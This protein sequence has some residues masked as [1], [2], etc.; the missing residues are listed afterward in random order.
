[1]KIVVID[2]DDLASAYGHAVAAGNSMSMQ[3]KAA[4]TEWLQ[5]CVNGYLRTMA[6]TQDEKT[7]RRAQGAVGAYED[8][9]DLLSERS[10]EV[11]RA[12]ARKEV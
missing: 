10:V 2:S 9:I 3:Q 1:M 11:T 6:S 5:Q 8:I 4:M 12:K 7:W